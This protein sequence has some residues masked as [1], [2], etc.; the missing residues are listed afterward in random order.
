MIPET[1]A[2]R[3]ADSLHRL[4]RDIDLA[5]L[6]QAH[7]DLVRRLIRG[8]GCRRLLINHC[9]PV[10]AMAR[11][12]SRTTTRWAEEPL[13]RTVGKDETRHAQYFV[14]VLES[15]LVCQNGVIIGFDRT[16]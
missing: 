11:G 10:P 4:L 5:C 2:L 9:H 3:H 14:H 15:S 6:E 8:Q 1:K 12:S 7:V 16:R 13:Q